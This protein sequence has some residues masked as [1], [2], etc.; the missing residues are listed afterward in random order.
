MTTT[1]TDDY[2]HQALV[3]D[4]TPRP[5]CGGAGRSVTRKAEVTCPACL[6]LDADRKARAE[7]HDAHAIPAGDEPVRDPSADYSDFM[8]LDPGLAEV[9][10]DGRGQRYFTVDLCDK[11]LLIDRDFVY[12]VPDMVIRKVGPLT[13]A[14]PVAEP[15]KTHDL[16]IVRAHG[17]VV[18]EAAA[19]TDGRAVY[20]QDGAARDLGRV[21]AVLTPAQIALLVD[22][23]KGGAK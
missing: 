16:S 14:Y 2:V 20:L 21:L 3:S 17:N 11:L 15:A 1:P 4:G 5:W 22:D 13:R 9:F 8:A 6:Q 7:V 10:A 12:D 23:L 18:I 19:E